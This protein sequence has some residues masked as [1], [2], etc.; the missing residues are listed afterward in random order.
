MQFTKD[1]DA[2]SFCD[3]CCKWPCQNVDEWTPWWWQIPTVGEHLI[4]WK[5]KEER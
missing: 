1:Y 3:G 4:C 2:P 5:P